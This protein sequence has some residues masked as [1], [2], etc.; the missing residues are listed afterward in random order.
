MN[1]KPLFFLSVI[2]LG[3]MSSVQA[4][5][6]FLSYENTTEYQSQK[7]VEWDAVKGDLTLKM[8]GDTKRELFEQI[9]E[10]G[11]GYINKRDLSEINDKDLKHWSDKTIKEIF[12]HWSP[13]YEQHLSSIKN[14]LSAVQEESQD[15]KLASDAFKS[16]E[17]AFKATGIPDLQTKHV[18][19]DAQPQIDKLEVV[20]EG[21]TET[22]EKWV[23][24]KTPMELTIFN[25]SEQTKFN[26][27]VLLVAVRKHKQHLHDEKLALIE[28]G[29]R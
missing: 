12:S 2:S 1:I 8:W 9:D 21:F 26:M 19:I 25:G 11:D 27:D 13:H 5:N 29:L 7:E 10:N 18:Y 3:W 14:K 23:T 17:K 4:Q 22:G 28:L 24:T 20:S 16:V 15:L 6:N